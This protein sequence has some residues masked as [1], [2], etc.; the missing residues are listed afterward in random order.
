MLPQQDPLATVRETDNAIII[1][2]NWWLLLYQL[3]QNSIGTPGTSPIGVPAS[4][5]TELAAADSDV[6]DT[7]AVVL[8]AQIANLN[9][10]S[11][12]ADPVPY[13]DIR[14][15]LILAQ[16]NL[17]ADP[18]PRA[19]PAIPVSP[20]GSPF[21]YTA[22]FP[23]V[24]SVTS[25]TVSQIQILRVTTTVATGITTGLIPL[26]RADQA[27]LTYT[28]APTLVFLPT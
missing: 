14:N 4:A 16:D 13:G 24:L 9:N 2:K 10:V 26:S 17:L 28:G 21:T 18:I 5:L 1:E 22:P 27:V 19:Q 23:G 8:R 12:E 25:G 11:G 7:D 6:A 15:A 3:C 20:T